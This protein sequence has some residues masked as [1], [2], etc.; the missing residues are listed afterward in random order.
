[1]SSSADE[2]VFVASLWA[3]R[4]FVAR[5]GSEFRSSRVAVCAGILEDN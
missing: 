3:D 4:F 1:M 2:R 5:V